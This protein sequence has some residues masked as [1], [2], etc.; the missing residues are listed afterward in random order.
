VSAPV[1]ADVDLEPVKTAITLGAG[2]LPNGTPTIVLRASTPVGASTYFLSPEECVQLG[3]MMVAAG[4]KRSPL[5]IASPGD[6]P[7]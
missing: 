2:L 7:T 6:V 4:S 3:E 1:P 5:V